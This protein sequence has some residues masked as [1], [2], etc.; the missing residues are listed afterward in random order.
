MTDPRPQSAEL[1][2]SD[3][4]KHE[5]AHYQKRLLEERRRLLRLLGRSAEQFS[6]STTESDG[7]LTS[8]PFHIAD[9]G[10][11]TIEQETGFLIASQESRMLWH[12][13]DALRR[14]YREPERFGICEHCGVA[15]TFERLDA[16]PHTRFCRTCKS[17]EVEP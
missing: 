17:Q 4:R 14:L 3:A 10:T 2:T 15:I 13:D 8:Y 1:P 9:Q 12:V 16:I 11:D 7:D 5:L 6:A